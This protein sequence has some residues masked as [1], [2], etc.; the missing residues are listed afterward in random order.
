MGSESDSA[1]VDL[2]ILKMVFRFV[3]SFAK[4]TF[5]RCRWRVN[6]RAGSGWITSPVKASKSPRAEWLMVAKLLPSFEH[7][8]AFSAFFLVIINMFCERNN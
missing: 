4:L 6:G 2:M 5:I 3:F 8:A 7:L 1:S